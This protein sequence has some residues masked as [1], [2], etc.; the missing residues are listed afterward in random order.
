MLHIIGQRE[1]DLT[2]FCSNSHDTSHGKGYRNSSVHPF[3]EQGVRSSTWISDCGA[4]L[5]AMNSE[6][7][8][9]ISP[10]T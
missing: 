8:R 1:L 7:S 5:N 6:G 9:P 10:E 4:E 2:P 3:N